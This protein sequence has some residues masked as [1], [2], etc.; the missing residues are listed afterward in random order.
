[1]SKP[2]LTEADK[3]LQQKLKEHFMKVT[4]ASTP[5]E[6]LEALDNLGSF[7]DKEPCISVPASQMSRLRGSLKADAQL[8]SEEVAQKLNSIEN[9]SQDASAALSKR[10]RTAVMAAQRA[11]QTI[12]ATGTS[13]LYPVLTDLP[14]L[15]LSLFI[16]RADSS[17]RRYNADKNPNRDS[18]N[19]GKLL[20]PHTAL[21]RLSASHGCSPSSPRMESCFPGLC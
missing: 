9:G 11:T 21:T 18:C 14:R 6:V 15:N 20:S 16:F 13:A 19:G 7:L 17:A 8:W 4:W 12:A 10:M 3:V 2:P 5:S 1:M